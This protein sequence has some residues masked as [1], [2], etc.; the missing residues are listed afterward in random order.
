VLDLAQVLRTAAGSTTQIEF[1]PKRPGEQLQSFLTVE[2]AKSQ[3]GWAAK[4]SLED[5]LADTFR[6]FGANTRTK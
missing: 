4:M 3:L 2:K 5:G 6:W 1:A